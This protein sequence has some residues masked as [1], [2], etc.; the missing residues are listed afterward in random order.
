[1]AVIYLA[2]F[3]FVLIDTRD[4]VFPYLQLGDV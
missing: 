4:I 1:M 2:A 3:S